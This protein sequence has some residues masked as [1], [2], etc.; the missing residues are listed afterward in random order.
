MEQESWDRPIVMWQ[1]E[2]KPVKTIMKKQG[3]SALQ[4]ELKKV[5]QGEISGYKQCLSMTVQFVSVQ[6]AFDVSQ[7]Q[8]FSQSEVG[9]RVKT[10]IKFSVLLLLHHFCHM[11]GH[12]A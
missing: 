10:E 11:G 4:N 5:F 3:N 2:E 8:K 9:D 1:C 12:S 6:Q 7:L